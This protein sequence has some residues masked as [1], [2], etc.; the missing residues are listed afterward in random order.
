[1]NLPLPEIS[2]FYVGFASCAAGIAIAVAARHVAPTVKAFFAPVESKVYAEYK[3]AVGAAHTKIDALSNAAASAINAV[4]GDVESVRMDIAYV[5]DRLVTL[6]KAVG[7]ADPTVA[8]AVAAMA[9]QVQA[10][11]VVHSAV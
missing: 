7:I 1:M 6:E 8:A 9:P 2:D 10:S 4:R 11:P 5:Q 3:A